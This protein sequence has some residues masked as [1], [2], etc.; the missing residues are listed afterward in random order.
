MPKFK[1]FRRKATS[2]NFG[3]EKLCAAHEIISAHSKGRSEQ[4]KTHSFLLCPTEQNIDKPCGEAQC[5]RLWLIE[6]V[7]PKV[8]L[9]LSN[10]MSI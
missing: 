2:P 9:P 4:V 7:P 3:S 6:P 5:F 8:T 1:F 10:F